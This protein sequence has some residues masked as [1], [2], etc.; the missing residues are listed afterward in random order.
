MVANKQPR[1]TAGTPEN[2]NRLRAAR[3]LM[4]DALIILD[5]TRAS[6]AAATLD[7]AIHALDRDIA[8]S[9]PS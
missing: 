1:G 5:D 3:Q 4:A 2:A 9:A 8:E 6:A 7:L